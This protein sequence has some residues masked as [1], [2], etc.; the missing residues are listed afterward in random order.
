MFF[1]EEKNLIKALVQLDW[2]A[3]QSGLERREAEATDNY[4]AIRIIKRIKKSNWDGTVEMERKERH[5][6]DSDKAN[7]A[8]LP[9]TWYSGMLYDMV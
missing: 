2:C 5:F 4:E 9:H 7:F 1:E 3:K 6:R 8:F